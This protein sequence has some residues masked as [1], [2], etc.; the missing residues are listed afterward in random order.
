MPEKPVHS[1][2]EKAG[3]DLIS[4]LEPYFTTQAPFQIPANGREMLVSW[5]PWINL[6]GGILCI[7]AFLSLLGLAGFVS[8]ISV[9]AG[10]SAG[11][12]IWI[13][14]LIL[15][16]QG[17]VHLIAFP[18]LRNNKLSAW[19]LLFWADVIFFI[20]NIVSGF[21]TPTGLISGI[22]GAIISVVIGM[23][24]LFQV[25]SYYK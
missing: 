2:G 4:Q 20:Y 15:L 1:S 10:Y 12:Y 11:T 17:V 25:K 23:Y 9:V 18:G 7:L 22:L 19:K 24:L 6:V 3:S 13:P 8:T 14:M 16:A 21:V 5:L